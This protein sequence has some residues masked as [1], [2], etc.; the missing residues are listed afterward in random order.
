M[1]NFPTTRP[2][3]EALLRQVQAEEEYTQRGRL[4]I[5]LGYSSGVGK[6]FRMLD[7]GRRRRERGEDVVVGAIQPVTPPEVACVLE[8]LEVIP[9][10]TVDG[11]A[12]MDLDAI[13]ARHPQVC[14]VDG[15]AYDNPPGCRNQKRWQDVAELLAAGIS[16]VATV[17]LQHIEERREQ[18]EKIT[19]QRVGETVPLPFINTADEIEIVDA[20]PEMC[21]KRSDDGAETEDPEERDRLSGLREIAL[22]LAADVVDRQLESYL[23]RHSIEPLWGVQER[24]LVYVAPE[25]DGAVMIRSGRRNADRFHGE[26]FVAYLNN[27]GLTREERQTLERSL[28]FARQ[29]SAAIEPLDGEEP[30]EKILEFARARG[31]TQIF[32]ARGGQEN[33]W[34]RLWGSELDDLI[35]RAEGMD[36]RVFP[37]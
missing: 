35:R 19:G 3:P 11:V 8:R 6:S 34:D 16:V 5:F 15:L 14:L 12:V 31:V 22:L 10:R 29:L 33:W 25:A 17:N 20:P 23:K 36:V 9:L 4:K 2:D 27:P 18:V 37:R 28:D 7:E 21:L 13:L 24:I 26:L 1:A 30:I 32:V